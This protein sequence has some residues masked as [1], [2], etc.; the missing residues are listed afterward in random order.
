MPTNQLT[1]NS[2]KT[3]IFHFPEVS[4]INEQEG[5]LNSLELEILSDLNYLPL[6]VDKRLSLE[7]HKKKFEKLARFCGSLERMQLVFHRKHLFNYCPS[8]LVFDH[9]VEKRTDLQ[10]FRLQAYTLC[11]NS[12]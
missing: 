12:D 8:F 3:K 7:N 1:L 6:F 5:S 10:Y 9:H 4:R 2:L 11:F